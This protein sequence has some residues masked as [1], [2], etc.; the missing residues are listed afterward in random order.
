MTEQAAE[1]EPEVELS[2]EELVALQDERW[3]RVDEVER[4]IEEELH[5]AADT[6]CSTAFDSLSSLFN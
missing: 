5:P 2:E 3:A 1:I 4:L 6:R